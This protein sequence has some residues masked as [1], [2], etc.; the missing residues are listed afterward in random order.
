M[1]AAQGPR[2]WWPQRPTRAVSLAPLGRNSASLEG[3]NTAL[4]KPRLARGLD[5]PQVWSAS[6][7]GWSPPRASLRL[8]RGSHGLTAPAPAPPT[9]AFNALSPAGSQVKDESTH[10]IPLTRLGII[11]WRCSANP[12][13]ESIPTTVRHCAVRPGSAPWHCATHSRMADTQHPRKRTAEPLKRGRTPI[14]RSPRAT[15]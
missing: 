6:L 14:P 8:V 1:I 12:P 3:H 7:E 15:P 13:G 11:S 9:R 2:P 4:T 5:A 10:A